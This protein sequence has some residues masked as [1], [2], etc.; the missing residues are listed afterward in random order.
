MQ[1]LAERSQA[2]TLT[3]DQGR[4]FDSCLHV[5]NLLAVMQSKARLVLA[6]PKPAPP[7]FVN[8]ALVRQSSNGPLA[9][10]SIVTFFPSS[11]ADGIA[12]AIN[13][14]GPDLGLAFIEKQTGASAVIASGS[15]VLM[16]ASFRSLAR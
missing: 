7:H 6:E 5:G 3:A 8:P 13:V 12:T 1:E 2:A 11:D 4:A 14:L 9:C 15:S 16:S 10:A